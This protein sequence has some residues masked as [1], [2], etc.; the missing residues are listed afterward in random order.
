MMYFVFLIM[1]LIFSFLNNKKIIKITYFIFSFFLG[2]IYSLRSDE[3]GNDT[4]NYLYYYNTVHN[5]YVVNSTANYF[6]PFYHFII[7]YSP[8]FEI[9]L[10][11]VS[12]LTFFLISLSFN[13]ITEWKTAFLFLLTFGFFNVAV[14]QSRQIL[15]LGFLIFFYLSDIDRLQ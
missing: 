8:T 1:I 5:P 7:T 10:F 2:L 9:Y 4:V 12:F 6:E 14:D 15:A 13:K 3:V 11:F